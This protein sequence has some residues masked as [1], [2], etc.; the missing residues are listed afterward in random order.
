MKVFTLKINGIITREIGRK[1]SAFVRKDMAMSSSALSNLS[2]LKGVDG[3][4]ASHYKGLERSYKDIENF[5]SV[6]EYQITNWG[7]FKKMLAGSSG[8]EVEMDIASIDARIA[9]LKALH[10]Q[11]RNALSR[12]GTALKQKSALPQKIKEFTN[13]VAKFT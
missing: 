12:V 1:D 13:T 8:K 5:M 6:V 4:L 3:L 11:L 7:N 9:D 2:L 10:G